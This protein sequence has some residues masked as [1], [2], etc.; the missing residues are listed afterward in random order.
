MKKMFK[1]VTASVMAVTAITVGMVGMS[2]SA[3]SE[4]DYGQLTGSRSGNFV[5]VNLHNKT[6]TSRY[7]QVNCFSY[8]ENGDYVDHYVKEGIVGGYNSSDKGNIG[9]KNIRLKAGTRYVAEGRLYL[10]EAPYGTP[11][12]SLDL[13]L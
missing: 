7:G 6:K 11:V 8:D 13:N 1:R 5:T 12:A 3:V 2:A 10:T 9:F 4:N